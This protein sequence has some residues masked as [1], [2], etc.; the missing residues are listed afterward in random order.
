V[1]ALQQ[2]E[3]DGNA[4]MRGEKI[5]EHELDLTGVADY[6]LSLDDLLTSGKAIPLHGARF[7]LAVEGRVAGRAHGVDYLGVRADGRTE[8]DLHLTIETDDDQRIA[9]SGDGQPAPRKV[10]R[11]STSL[12]TSDSPPPPKIRVGQ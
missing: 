11:Y 2:E 6:G 9:L 3:Q 7:D 5:Y 10:S 12:G 4:A 1:E 8:L